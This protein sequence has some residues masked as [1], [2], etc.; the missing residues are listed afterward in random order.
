M[1]QFAG[2]TNCSKIRAQIDAWS[3]A[4]AVIKG[5]RAP[6]RACV[7][8]PNGFEVARPRRHD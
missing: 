4:D 3:P 2:L 5:V 6:W 7:K 8:P 1:Y